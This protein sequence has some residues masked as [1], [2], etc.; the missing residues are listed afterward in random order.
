MRISVV[1]P[2]HNRKAL[3]RR[4][5]AAVTQ[6]DYP[7]YEVIVV[8][9]GST[10][11]T[12]AMVRNEFPQVRYLRQEPNRGP[13]AARNR[14]IE[15]ATGEVVAFTDDDCIVP[16]D[17]LSALAQGFRRW[18]EVAGVGGYQEAP[19]EI[20]QTNAVARAERA[21]RLRR[22]GERAG[23]EQL[24]GNE[25][26]GLATNNVAF[27][28]DVLLEVEGFDEGFPVA[29]GEDADLKLRIAQRGYQLLYIPLKVD[30]YRE[31]TCRAQWR[32]HLRRG[33]GVHYFEAKHGTAPGLGRVVL[34]LLKRTAL[35]LTDL[36][37][38]PWDVAAIIYLGQVADCAGQIVG[39]FDRS[40]HPT[41]TQPRRGEP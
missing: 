39:Q 6:Q 13:A 32:M 28:R 36:W 3:L 7:H 38:L 15:A 20:L 10:D 19:E 5:L 16:T 23:M 11:G 26:P 35:F 22:W 2:T 34:R 41:G 12:E 17:W 21:M 1:I 37:A 33:I 8:D 14:G 40:A 29:A 27:R 31:Y 4:C 9:D 24:G 30:H 18:P 25:V